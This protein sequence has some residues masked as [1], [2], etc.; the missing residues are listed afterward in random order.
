MNP[1]AA[2]SVPVECGIIWYIVV[3]TLWH[4]ELIDVPL[5]NANKVETPVCFGCYP[6][7]CKP[8]GGG[9]CWAGEVRREA[10]R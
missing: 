7:P 6:P 9:E 3:L 5:C 10:G 2:L 1:T 8:G 4:V